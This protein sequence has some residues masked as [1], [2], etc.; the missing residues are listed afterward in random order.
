M[1]RTYKRS[2]NEKW[3]I[4]TIGKEWLTRKKSRPLTKP[5]AKPSSLL[6]LPKELLYFPNELLEKVLSHVSIALYWS[7]NAYLLLAIIASD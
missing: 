4:R 1:A 6:H 2:T 3:R 7:L 5:V